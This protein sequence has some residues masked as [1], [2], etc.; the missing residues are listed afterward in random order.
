[1][2]LCLDG[3]RACPPEDCGGPWGYENLQKI[4]RNPKHEEHDSMKG[5]LGHPLDPEAF[6]AEKVNTYLQRLKWPRTMESQLRKV[7][8][9]RDD[10]DE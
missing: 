8:M 7:L 10:Y 1:V 9:A 5:W 2:A 6:D 3:A 4:L